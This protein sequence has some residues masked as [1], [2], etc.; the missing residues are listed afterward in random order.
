VNTGTFV[1]RRSDD[2]LAALVAEG[3]QQAFAVLYERYHQQL[4]RY[5][6]S[7]LHNDGDAQDAL[8]STMTAALAALRRGVPRAP[9]RPWLYRIAHNESISLIRER[10]KVQHSTSIAEPVTESAEERADERA[11]FAQLMAD[12]SALPERQRAALLMHELSGLSHDDIALALDTSPG[13][14]RQLIFD[15]RRALSAFASGRAMQCDEVRRMVSDGDGRML[16]AHN[17]RAHVRDCAGCHAFA[18]SIKSRRV[19][20]NAVVPLLGPAAAA[21]LLARVLGASSARTAAASSVGGASV[22]SAKLLAG[23]AILAGGVTTLV[24]TQNLPATQSPRMDRQTAIALPPLTPLSRYPHLLGTNATGSHTH[25]R[26]QHRAAVATAGRVAGR[27]LQRQT[28]ARAPVTRRG[29]GIGSVVRKRTSVPGS[30]SA[31]PA[32][33]AGAAPAGNRGRHLD[34]GAAQ[35]HLGVGPPKSHGVGP[36]AR[37]GSGPASTRSAG[38]RAAKP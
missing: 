11:R 20:L 27:G 7:I 21:K 19:A 28:T 37:K 4:Y 22:I 2:R 16:R 8:Q 10:G 5:C 15:A 29:G 25:A 36:P 6:R 18:T 3:N 30:G 31:S 9:L 24:T 14:S 33:S 1:G 32:P 35:N 17:I 38:S 34:R 12:L 13:A 26:A 23:A